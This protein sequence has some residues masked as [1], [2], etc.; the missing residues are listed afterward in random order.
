VPVH[1]RDQLAGKQICQEGPGAP[2]G[3]EVESA[4]CPCSREGQ[5][6]PGLLWEEHCQQLKGRSSPLH[7]PGEATPGVLGP[8][9]GLPSTR[10]TVEQNQQ[11]GTKMIKEGEHL[12]YGER[13]GLFGQEKQRLRGICSMWINNLLGGNEKEGARLL[14]VVPSDRTNGTN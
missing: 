11:R 1:T 2:A 3:Q 12:S 7:S 9:A 8:S 14:S 13:L 10:M 6:Y 5:R 4:M